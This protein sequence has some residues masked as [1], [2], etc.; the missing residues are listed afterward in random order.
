MLTCSVVALDR[1]LGNEQ[2]W[3]EDIPMKTSQQGAA[4]TVYAAFEPILRGERLID[5]L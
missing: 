2:G 5:V 4:T 1:A 3:R